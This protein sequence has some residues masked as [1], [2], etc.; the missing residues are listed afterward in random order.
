MSS[1]ACICN[2]YNSLSSYILSQNYDSSTPIFNTRKVA[3]KNLE[4]NQSTRLPPEMVYKISKYLSLSDFIN[5]SST[6]SNNYLNLRSDNTLFKEVLEKEPSYN[7]LLFLKDLRAR[8]NDGAVSTNSGKTSKSRKRPVPDSFNGSPKRRTRA[9]S[10]RGKL[11][12]EEYKPSHF[13]YHTPEAAFRDG[14]AKID[15]HNIDFAD[16]LSTEDERNECV[17]RH[18]VA[19][20]FNILCR[21]ATDD[22]IPSRYR[23]VCSKH[24][25]YIINTRAEERTFSPEIF[26]MNFIIAAETLDQFGDIKKKEKI[27]EYLFNDILHEGP[28]VKQLTD[29]IRQVNNYPSRNTEFWK[30]FFEGIQANSG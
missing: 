27:M 9:D 30:V 25:I 8:A 2:K 5:F 19:Q 12:Y 13:I 3:R 15:C 1:P 24:A 20:F 4:E 16:I 10:E 7:E 26:A 23:S 28:H 6:D 29:T 21:F 14:P 18:W 11:K 17:R 22:G